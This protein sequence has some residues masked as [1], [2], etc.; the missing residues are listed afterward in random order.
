VNELRE[1]HLIAGEDGDSLLT[2]S[3]EEQ[4]QRILAARREL[5]A[6][7]LA[8]PDAARSSELSALLHR[9]ARELCGE[10]PTGNPAQPAA[11]V[12]DRP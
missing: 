12:S 1:R 6:D 2:P 11:S 4:T 3:G 10:P 5:L 9:L 8:D 7:A